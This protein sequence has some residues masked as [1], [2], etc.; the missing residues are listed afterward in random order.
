MLHTSVL[1]TTLTH[2]EEEAGARPPLPAQANVD[3]DQGT[4]A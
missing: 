3:F 1:V 2:L 4:L